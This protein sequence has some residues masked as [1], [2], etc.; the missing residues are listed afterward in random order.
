HHPLMWR[1]LG[2]AARR[3]EILEGNATGQSEFQTNQGKERLNEQQKRA[4][5]YPNTP[6]E[7]G[8]GKR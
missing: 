4:R 1:L 5:M 3:W 7:L 2:D 8:G 6:A